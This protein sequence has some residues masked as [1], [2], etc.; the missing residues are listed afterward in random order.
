M[1]KKSYERRL[2][3]LKKGKKV[4]FAEYERILKEY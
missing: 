3:R 1:I 2:K 4:S